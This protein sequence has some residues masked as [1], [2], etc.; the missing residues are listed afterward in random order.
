M[1]QLISVNLVKD[2]T[3]SKEGASV[4]VPADTQVQYDPTHELAYWNGDRFDLFKDEF[5]MTQ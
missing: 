1:F 3:F 5:C 4:T 2:I